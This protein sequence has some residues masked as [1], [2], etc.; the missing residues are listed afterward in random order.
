[1][2]KQTQLKSVD[3][4]FERRTHT[5]ISLPPNDDSRDSWLPTITDSS[6]LSGHFKKG[7]AGELNNRDR[8]EK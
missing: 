1:V 3:H 6:G 4:E 7:R 2:E 8:E 5:Q